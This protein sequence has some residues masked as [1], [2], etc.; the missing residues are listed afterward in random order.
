M[1][2]K[3]RVGDTVTVTVPNGSPCRTMPHLFPNEPETLSFTGTVVKPFSWMSYSEFCLTSDDPLWPVRIINFKNVLSVNGA[4]V[5]H[6]KVEQPYT[7]TFH[8][9]GKTGN[10]HIVTFV[11]DRVSCDCKGFSFR[12]RCSHVD[13]T[14]QLR[15]QK[16][17]KGG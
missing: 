11:G 13:S 5:E 3:P 10:D 7:E 15:E 6:V 1:N 2:T 16:K 12:R 17:K 4:N 14:N 8:V 9:K